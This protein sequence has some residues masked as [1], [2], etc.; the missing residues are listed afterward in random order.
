MLE[1]RS[2]PSW[3]VF[4]VICLCACVCVIHEGGMGWH[5][6]HSSRLWGSRTTPKNWFSPA[7]WWVWGL[8]LNFWGLHVIS[9]TLPSP[10]HWLLLP[11]TLD[12]GSRPRIENPL[13]ITELYTWVLTFWFY[14]EG[15]NHLN[16]PD[17]L[18][19]FLLAFPGCAQPTSCWSRCE[20]ATTFSQQTLWH[21]Q[22][23]CSAMV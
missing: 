15:H 22:T 10:F 16:D 11:Y 20:G 7:T 1:L 23:T 9:S 19:I 6:C 13:S 3:F 4:T 2:L 5:M 14:T 17:D 8:N 18:L 12:E 21:L